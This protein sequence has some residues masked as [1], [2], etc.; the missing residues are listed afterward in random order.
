MK[1]IFVVTYQTLGEIPI[2]SI[3]FGSYPH[4]ER[5]ILEEMENHNLVCTRTEKDLWDFGDWN[6]RITEVRFFP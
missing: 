6:Y 2:L 3:A 1:T 4:A 5:W